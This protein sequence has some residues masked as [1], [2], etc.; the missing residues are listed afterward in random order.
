M[1]NEVKKE[2]GEY[3]NR[4]EGGKRRVSGCSATQFQNID[5]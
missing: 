1:K 5:K 3:I 2:E 4:R